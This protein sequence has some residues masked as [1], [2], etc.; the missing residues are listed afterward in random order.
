MLRYIIGF[1]GA[2]RSQEGL[3][4]VNSNFQLCKYKKSPFSALSVV[5]LELMPQGHNLSG[6]VTLFYSRVHPAPYNRCSIQSLAIRLPTDSGY[7]QPQV[8]KCR[9]SSRVFQSV[10]YS[11]V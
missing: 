11:F 1:G 2:T 6:P 7:F 8:K 3:Q 10:S 5:S 4:E 9:K